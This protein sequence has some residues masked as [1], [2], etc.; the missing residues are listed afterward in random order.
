MKRII[1]LAL[2][3]VLLLG[4]LWA[5]ELDGIW[6]NFPGVNVLAA[7]LAGVLLIRL[8]KEIR[9]REQENT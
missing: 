9:R 5:L 6:L 8:S 7:I 2:M 1:A 3:A 4:S